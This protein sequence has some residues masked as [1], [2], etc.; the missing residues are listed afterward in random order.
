MLTLLLGKF[1][2]KTVSWTLLIGPITSVGK[3]SSFFSFIKETLELS[4]KMRGKQRLPLGLLSEVSN[5]WTTT[6]AV[7]QHVWSL[8]LW[9]KI[10]I[11]CCNTFIENDNSN[12]TNKWFEKYTFP[13][14]QV[15]KNLQTGTEESKGWLDVEEKNPPSI[16]LRKDGGK[17]RRVRERELRGKKRER[18]DP[19]QSTWRVVLSQKTLI[20]WSTLTFTFKWNKIEWMFLKLNHNCNFTNIDKIEVTYT[21]QKNVPAITPC[22]VAV[23]H[24]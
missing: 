9:T 8:K 7:Q 24:S 3:R 6:S 14:C 17:E 22:F 23:I 1:H 16:M 21:G 4:R 11:E 19:P 20:S 15:T 10:N 5:L 18:E 12:H 13:R 2:L